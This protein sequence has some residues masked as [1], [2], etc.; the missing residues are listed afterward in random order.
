MPWPSI[1]KIGF[2]RVMH[3][4]T[5]ESRDG[6]FHGEAC[7]LCTMIFQTEESDRVVVRCDTSLLAL[8][9][10]DVYRRAQAL[11]TASIP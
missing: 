8:D 4:W 2:D 11:R 10:V 3:W 5:S 9:G 6:K 7:V 1:A